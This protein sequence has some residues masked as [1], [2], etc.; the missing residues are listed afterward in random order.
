MPFSCCNKTSRIY[1]DKLA[2][3]STII[4]ILS[5]LPIYRTFIEQCYSNDN[6]CWALKIKHLLDSLG[7]SYIWTDFNQDVNY[8]PLIKQRLRDQYI[9]NWQAQS[10]TSPKLKYYM[11]YKHNFEYE[12]YFDIISNNAIRNELTRFRL[13]SHDLEIETGRF[14]GIARDMRSCKLCQYNRLESEYHFLLCCPYYSDIRRKYLG[15]ISWPNIHKFV[16]LLSSTNKKTILNVAKYI[17]EAVK[18]RTATLVN[19]PAS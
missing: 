1:S 8:F 9:Q 3:C 15:I 7:L 4:R 5:S 13:C 6:N 16:A 2:A 17:Y 11:K 14:S 19:L 10:M 18:K 12:K